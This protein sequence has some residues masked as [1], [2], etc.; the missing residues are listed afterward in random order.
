M[1]GSA[2]SVKVVPYSLKR[3]ESRIDTSRNASSACL[4]IIVSVSSD[5]R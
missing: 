3:F 5:S 1:S 4:N 2:L